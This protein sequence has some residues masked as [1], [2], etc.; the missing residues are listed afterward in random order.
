MKA[1]AVWDDAL[2]S[3]SP[4]EI[5]DLAQRVPLALANVSVPEEEGGFRETG[6]LLTKKQVIDL[7]KYE[8]AALALPFTLTD[9]KDYLNFGDDEGGGAGLKHEDFR[10]TFSA[11]RNH[12]LRWSPLRESIMLTGSEL[13]LFASSMS[14]YGDA[15]EDIYQD[16]R[17]SVL[18]EKYDIKT[19]DQLKKIEMELGGKFP[20]IELE[21]NT[22]SDLGYYLEQIFKRIKDNL[23]NVKAIKETLAVFGYDLREYILP[24]IKFRLSLIASTSLPAEVERLKLQIDERAV[25]IDEKN[26]EYKEAVNKSISAALGLNIVGLAM[27]IYL[28]VEAENIRAERNRL[29]KEQEAEIEKLKNKNQTLGSLNR[30]KYDLQGLELVSVDA[31]IATQNLMYVW[32]VLH[33]YVK[34]SQDAVAEIHDA[35][36]LRRFMT[37]FRL[38]VSPW[39][40]IEIDADALIAVFKA[41]DEE[42]ERNYGV[43]QGLSR[44]IQSGGMK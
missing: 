44:S 1:N 12:A 39:K 34:S 15:M 43:N 38:V 10:K 35:L 19:L 32:N 33:L 5:T 20:G 36:S 26:K 9:V 28:G 21:S 27:A 16:V 42:Y 37:A 30:V 8:A 3:I 31:D 6:L 7:R 13:K 22:V 17:A 18:L 2:K 11:T 4:E 25:R 41:A 23:G 14:I 29:Y 40:Q 24:D